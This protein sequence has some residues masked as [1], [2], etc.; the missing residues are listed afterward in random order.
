MSAVARVDLEWDGERLYATAVMLPAWRALTGS[1][2]ESSV[3]VSGFCLGPE[4]MTTFELGVLLHQCSQHI[5]DS[6]E[7]ERVLSRS[8]S[9]TAV[10]FGPLL[11]GK[12]TQEHDLNDDQDQEDGVD[13]SH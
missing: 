2:G 3:P 12:V 6:W 13:R 7:Y 11:K 4:D 9:G 5:L 1:P 10:L 8:E